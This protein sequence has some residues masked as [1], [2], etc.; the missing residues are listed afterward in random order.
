MSLDP[1]WQLYKEHK[2]LI[3]N[4]SKKKENH[5]PKNDEKKQTTD[6]NPTTPSNNRINRPIQQP[7]RRGCCG[8]G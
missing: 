7:R 4:P 6:S 2:I 8:K 5:Q 1:R 3:L